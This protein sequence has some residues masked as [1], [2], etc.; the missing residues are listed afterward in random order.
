MTMHMHSITYPWK[1]GD[2]VRY[3]ETIIINSL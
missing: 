3:T 1:N 2:D